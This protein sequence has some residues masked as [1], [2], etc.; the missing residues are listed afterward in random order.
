MNRPTCARHVNSILI[1]S[2]LYDLIHWNHL[3]EKHLKSLYNIYWV[4]QQLYPD[5]SIAINDRSGID[6]GGLW[7]AGGGELQAC[8]TRMEPEGID[9]GA[10]QIVLCQ[11]WMEVRLRDWMEGR[12]RDWIGRAAPAVFRIDER[13]SKGIF[14]SVYELISR[15]PDGDFDYI[16]DRGRELWPHFLGLDRDRQQAAYPRVLEEI[17]RVNSG[18]AGRAIRSILVLDDHYRKFFLGDAC[19][20]FLYNTKRTLHKISTDARCRINCD[21]EKV[22]GRLAEMF[23]GSFGPNTEFTCTAWG[24]IDFGSYDLVLCHPDSIL[25]LLCHLER[26]YPDGLP[27]TMVY[28]YD[29]MMDARNVGDPYQWNYRLLAK[30]VVPRERVHVRQYGLALADKEIILGED[31]RGWADRWLEEQGVRPGE[32]VAILI[33]G[34]STDNKLLA[35]DVFLGLMG[36]LLGDPEMKILLYDEMGS[37]K[38]GRLVE[39]YGEAFAGRIIVATSLGLRKDMCLLGSSYVRSVIGP[40][41]G[42]L[43]L[44]NSI[45]TYLLNHGH[46]TKT[47]LPLL[48]VYTGRLNDLNPD[49]NASHWWIGSLVKC[50]IISKGEN[51][52]KSIRKLGQCPTATEEYRR[53][54]LPVSEFTVPLL[55]DFIKQII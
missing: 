37:G 48:M 17:R 33:E 31:E 49:Y 47:E 42:M 9:W 3:Q 24:G 2:D 35:A 23:R 6:Y 34:A 39:L 44:A 46:L 21:N 11:P 40:C 16:R 30:S 26:Y 45:Y 22:Y 38:A 7:G 14:P 15:L 19:F 10:Y 43:H 12:V 51:G 18:L 27:G 32:K 52:E 20:W 54:T 4:L 29:H 53:V 25:K 36:W 5:A 28:H 13:G 50:A 55:T 1:L 41:T 8:V